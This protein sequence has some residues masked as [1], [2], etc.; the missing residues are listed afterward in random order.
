MKLLFLIFSF[1]SITYAHPVHLSVTNL[2]YFENN[3]YFHLSIRLFVD[4]FE[5]ILNYNNNIEI[6]LGK[7]N[8]HNEADFFITKYINNNFLIEVNNQTIPANKYI[9]TNYEIKDISIWLTFKI[10]HRKN[11]DSITITNKLMFDLFLD[12]KNMLIFTQNNKQYAIDF[13]PDKS[14]QTINL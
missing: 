6:N 10:R 4:D 13:E 12:Q 7:P 2:E 3:N 8:E 5:T 9:L 11:F 14:Q 1:S